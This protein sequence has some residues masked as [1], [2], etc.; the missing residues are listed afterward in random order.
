MRS[1]S[2]LQQLDVSS[3]CFEITSQTSSAKDYLL[4]LTDVFND[5]L[6]PLSDV[7][8]EVLNSFDERVFLFLEFKVYTHLKV[9]G[10]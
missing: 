1:A 5:I 4:E 7:G 6:T 10:F 8:T 2:P 3:R 9:K